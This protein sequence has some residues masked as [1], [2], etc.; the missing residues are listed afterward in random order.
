MCDKGRLS[1]PA[2][3]PWRPYTT[4][5]SWPHQSCQPSANPGQPQAFCPSFSEAPH[6][7]LRLGDS[8]SCLSIS[9]PRTVAD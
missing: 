6:L 4:T 8:G 5:P 9:A 7:S 3:P 2:R 1:S